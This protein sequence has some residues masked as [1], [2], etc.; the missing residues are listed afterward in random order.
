MERDHLA[1]RVVS[2]HFGKVKSNAPG[3]Q[4][5][6]V[7]EP[8]ADNRKSGL[9]CNF[10]TKL[11]CGATTHHHDSLGH[12]D[13]A[14]SPVLTAHIAHRLQPRVVS[15]RVT[16]ALIK[17]DVTSVTCN[18]EEVKIHEGFWRMYTRRVDVETKDGYAPAEASTL[19]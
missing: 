19:G 9:A 6:S 15:C 4:A 14:V 3:Q 16:D 7:H 12:S 18:G 17:E 1:Y 11:C 5:P 10:R 13:A 2:L 8:D